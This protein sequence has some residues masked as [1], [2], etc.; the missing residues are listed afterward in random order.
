MRKAIE[1]I[2]TWTN[3]K[4]SFEKIEEILGIAF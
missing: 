2:V 3:Y 4:E 1:R